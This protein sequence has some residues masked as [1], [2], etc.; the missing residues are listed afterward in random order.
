MNDYYLLLQRLN[1]QLELTLRTHTHVYVQVQPA[2]VLS[3]PQGRAHCQFY[4]PTEGVRTERSLGEDG[5]DMDIP[6]H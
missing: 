6:V 2:G 4:S 3:M 1:G 5:S